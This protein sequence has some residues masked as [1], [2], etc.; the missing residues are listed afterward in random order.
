MISQA[1]EILFVSVVYL[2]FLLLV[3]ADQYKMSSSSQRIYLLCTNQIIQE[4]AT[5][6]MK[7]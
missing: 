1:H 3:L 4:H 5:L 7:K 6:F 2:P